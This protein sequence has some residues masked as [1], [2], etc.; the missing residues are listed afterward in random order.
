M[1]IAASM[2]IKIPPKNELRWFW[3]G[4]LDPVSQ[5]KPK[6]TIQGLEGS[7]KNLS[8]HISLKEVVRRIFETA[9]LHFGA[10]CRKLW[11]RRNVFF[12]FDFLIPFFDFLI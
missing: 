10:M 9:H 2:N 8:L 1:F 6:G 4:P 7:C 12:A 3:I 5:A 11:K